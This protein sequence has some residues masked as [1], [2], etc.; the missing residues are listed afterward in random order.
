MLC[1]LVLQ[2]VSEGKS[3]CLDSGAL[4]SNIIL[5]GVPTTVP[6]LADSLR[7]LPKSQ[8]AVSGQKAEPI[9]GCYGLGLPKLPAVHPETMSGSSKA[10]LETVC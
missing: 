2:G 8:A 1:L 5:S 6:S 3:V 9:S 10:V 4:D 7:L